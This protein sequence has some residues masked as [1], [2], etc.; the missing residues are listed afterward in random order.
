MEHE[1][2]KTKKQSFNK[3][4]RLL[5]SSCSANKKEGVCSSHRI[6]EDELEKA[7]VTY[8]NSYIDELEKLEQGIKLE[9]VDYYDGDFDD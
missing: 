3:S 1:E 7:V 5:A 2:T 6:R 4:F 8:L 9:G